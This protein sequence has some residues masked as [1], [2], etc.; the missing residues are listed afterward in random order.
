VSWIAHYQDDAFIDHL[1]KN[2]IMEK[3]FHKIVKASSIISLCLIAIL[4]RFTSE[5]QTRP[6][7]CLEALTDSQPKAI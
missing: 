7:P 1:K 2:I 4:K 3:S 6:D 5:M